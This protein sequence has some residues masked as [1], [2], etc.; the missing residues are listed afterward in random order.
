MCGVAFVRAFATRVDRLDLPRGFEPM[1]LAGWSLG[2]LAYVEYRPP[3]ALC[4]RE[5][6]WMPAAVRTRDAFG[7]EHSGWYVDRIYV[8]DER[9]LQGGRDLWALPKEM[10]RFSVSDGGVAMLADDGA[11]VA[12]R[13]DRA[14]PA[15]SARGHLVALQAEPGGLVRLRA[16]ATAAASLARLDVARFASG[17]RH[18]RAF[19]GRRALPLPA[20]ALRPFE[21]TMQAPERSE[22]RAPG[23]FGAAP[24]PRARA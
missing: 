10:A 19:D 12:L 1:Q 3:S 7:R 2:V 14:G 15:V 13:F 20:L 23:S 6:I 8:D 5:L 11:E 22:R 9:G 4:Y 21:A 18:W 16:D 24:P 17:A